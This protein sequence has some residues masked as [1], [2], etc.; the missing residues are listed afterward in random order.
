M[1]LLYRSVN[2]LQSSIYY[3]K[4][5][6]LERLNSSKLQAAARRHEGV[7]HMHD[8]VNA[9]NSTN[10]SKEIIRRRKINRLHTHSVTGLDVV[11]EGD[12]NAAATA[13]DRRNNRQAPEIYS[14][15]EPFTINGQTIV[16][17]GD[18]NAQATQNRRNEAKKKPE[19]Y[20]PRE[21]KDIT[22]QEV[23][24]EGD[25]N[26]RNTN[27]QRRKNKPA[28][29]IYEPKEGND[30]QDKID[31]LTD[32]ITKLEAE[33]AELRR[34]NEVWE[35]RLR[36]AEEQ[37]RILRK[38]ITQQELTDDEM[39]IATTILTEEVKKRATKTPQP[40]QGDTPT[41][42]E[43][44]D[45]PKKD[46]TKT[47]PKDDDHT[48]PTGP[49]KNPTDETNRPGRP[50]PPPPANP[51]PNHNNRH[52]R[53]GWLRNGLNPAVM[54]AIAT[55]G[56][57][58]R[59]I[60]GAV[61]FVAA[62][63]AGLTSLAGS[64]WRRMRGATTMDELNRYSHID[65][66]NWFGRL[67]QNYTRR[68]ERD[69]V[70]LSAAGVR[71]NVTRDMRNM[72]IDTGTETP[73]IQTDT[74]TGVS[75]N[76]NVPVIDIDQFMNM[77]RPQQ[78]RILGEAQRH[79]DA[80]DTALARGVGM[81]DRQ[82]AQAL[83]SRE[84]AD[85]LSQM[86]MGIMYSGEDG[87]P[88]L[89]DDT[90][91][92]G[93]YDEVQRIENRNHTRAMFGMAGI[94]FVKAA[95]LTGIGDAIATIAHFGNP[96][97]G[98]PAPKP[99]V[100]TETYQFDAKG[101]SKGFFDQPGHQTMEFA[102]QKKGD[103]RGWVQANQTATE[104]GIGSWQL[105]DGHMQWV[106]N[107]HDAKQVAALHQ[108]EVQNPHLTDQQVVDMWNQATPIKGQPGVRTLGGQVDLTNFYKDPKTGLHDAT[109]DFTNGNN[110]S[111]V[112]KDNG[113]AWPQWAPI[114]GG[115]EHVYG[116]MNYADRITSVPGFWRGQLAQMLHGTSQ[117]LVSLKQEYD[118][119]IAA[120]PNSVPESLKPYLTQLN[121]LWN[122]YN[123][124][125]NKDGSL[126]WN[127][128]K[129]SDADSQTIIQAINQLRLNMPAILSKSTGLKA[130]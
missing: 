43:G 106:F 95:V 53:R 31:A 124:A 97:G 39:K 105:K 102:N 83:A 113:L 64:A 11:A 33:N 4:M 50:T 115:L 48:P 80:V 123:F 59:K 36:D 41:T 66:R 22:G 60:A 76:A 67:L 88:A 9:G 99:G 72:A 75:T 23:V 56:V 69:L 87:R 129:L 85:A 3:I 94:A 108:V 127:S 19:I 35:K 120:N 104:Q 52:D 68:A 77:P 130:S 18:E 49:V 119:S 10:P 73:A 128:A 51:E 84:E 98:S 114:P 112:S 38:I 32:R 45:G 62:P 7:F 110:V 42:G 96:F 82:R 29:E 5:R 58:T 14:A 70:W 1:H 40:G 57:A 86:Y 25:E 30:L 61:P 8:V 55:A 37:N 26:A 122:K 125:I 74:N 63:V 71:S 109:I 126:K 47:E 2:I 81:S 111:W 20:E 34:Q 6:N 100:K 16:S 44:K 90:L 93:M 27:E 24:A 78:L 79:I 118:Y 89:T 107:P 116:T 91:V 92:N 15:K 17:E 12:K 46:E 117:N 21:P 54:S 28:P 103:L 13:I 101:N 121:E 65:S